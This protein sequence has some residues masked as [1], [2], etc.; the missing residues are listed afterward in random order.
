M[1]DTSPAAPKAVPSPRQV[2]HEEVDRAMVV[3]EAKV[4][5]SQLDS[6]LELF[7]EWISEGTD[8]DDAE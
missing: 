8:D 3:A 5:V 6:Y 4:L 7:S 2:V 1:A